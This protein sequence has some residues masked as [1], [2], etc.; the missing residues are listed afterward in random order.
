IINNAIKF[1]FTGQ[2]TFDVSMIDK[3]IRFCVQ[4]TGIG[5][6]KN[7]LDKI[8]KAF[9]QLEDQSRQT[10][11]T[12]LGLAISKR[13]VK[14]M[15]GDICVESEEGKGSKFWFEISLPEVFKKKKNE[16]S[17]KWRNV[18]GDGLRVLIVDDNLLNRKF[19]MQMLKMNNFE[20]YEAENGFQAVEQTE[21]IRPHLIL[22]DVMMPVM[23]GIEA[24]SEIR[25][26]PANKDIVIF[27]IS[28]N[29]NME[30]ECQEKPGT[31][32]EFFRKP[33]DMDYFYRKEK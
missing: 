29:T 9:H 30:N 5:I 8:F 2:V 18:K 22:M 12:G 31:C 4:D 33:I 13:I 23:N 24:M 11:G 10:E 20:I 27:A 14:M 28:A 17:H 1:T 3:K 26:N 15:G 25:K 16:N 6:P 32:N 21:L 7:K 19:F